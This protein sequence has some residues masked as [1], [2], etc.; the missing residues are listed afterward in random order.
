MGICWAY[1]S[2]DANNDLV[3]N[4]VNRP[5]LVKEMWASGELSL[6]HQWLGDLWFWAFANLK[7]CDKKKTDKEH[8]L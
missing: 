7:F 1:I 6:H 2:T 4:D 3:L 5:Q 8:E